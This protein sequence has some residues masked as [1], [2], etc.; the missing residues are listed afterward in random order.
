M[1][2][3]CQ[4]RFNTCNSTRYLYLGVT[5][6]V[7]YIV[8]PLNSPLWENDLVWNASYHTITYFI[9][10]EQVKQ[11]KWKQFSSEMAGYQK[12]HLIILANRHS[13]VIEYKHIQQRNTQQKRRKNMDCGP[14]DDASRSKRSVAIQTRSGGFVSGIVAWRRIAVV[15]SAELLSWMVAAVVTTACWVVGSAL[16]RLYCIDCQAL[17]DRIC[18]NNQRQLRP[19]S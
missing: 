14:R 17:I 12:S 4:L 9:C 11:W 16:G 3:D 15:K 2:G 8:V 1:L 6:P 19:P 10:R 7:V 5:S 13:N 18:A